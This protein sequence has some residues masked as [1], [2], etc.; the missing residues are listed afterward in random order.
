MRRVDGLAALVISMAVWSTA[1]ASAQVVTVDGAPQQTQIVVGAD[2]QTYVG[3]WITAPDEPVRRERAPMDVSLVI[4]VSGS[5]A[6]EKIANARSAAQSLLETLRNGDI[7]S[8]YAFS[9]DVYEIAAPMVVGE[10]TRGDLIRR[11]AQLRDLGSTNLFGGLAAGLARMQQAPASHPIRR[12]IVISDGQANVGPSDPVSLGN[13][14]AGGTESHAQ[15]TA[16]GVGLDYDENTLGQL[17]VRSQGRLYHLANPSQMAAI[18]REEMGLL[19]STF[20]TDV[21]IEVQPAP[22]VI[23]VDGLTMGSS[24]SGNTLRIPVGNLVAGQSRELLFRAR[25]DTSRVGTRPLAT[26]RVM[27]A[28]TSDAS[29]PVA[30]S[31]EIPYSVTADA[32]AAT[33]SASPRVAGLVATHEASVA[34]LAAAQ[35]LSRGDARAADAAFASA[36]ASLSRAAAVAPPAAAAEAR[37]RRERIHSAR[38]AAATAPSATSGAGRGAALDAFD[39]AYE[40][41]AY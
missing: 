23:I 34:S 18:L 41:N 26:A 7:V 33:R 27:Y 36:E 24:M 19:A 22:G 5:M 25:V 31:V 10:G 6:G 9:D 15:V 32:S 12:V 8:I 29:R 38:S 40:M 4:D 3:I 39:S 17:A 16:I 37:S 28:P 13:L 14:A 30:R 35:A 2:G 1:V 20:A 21:M 11:V